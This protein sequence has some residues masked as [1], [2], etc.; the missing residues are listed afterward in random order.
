LSSTKIVII[1][2]VL[3]GLLFVIF[4]VRGGLR[5]DPPPPNNNERKAN[6]AKQQPPGWT[7]KIEGLFSSLKPKRALEKKTYST[8]ATEPISPDQKQAFRTIKFHLLDGLP[9]VHYKNNTPVTGDLHDLEDQDC[10]KLDNPKT[11]DPTHCSI[12]AL[13]DGG[14]ITISCQGTN[15]PCRVEVE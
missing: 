1:V 5:H 9:L 8:N 3:I 15:I 7:K 6:A 10:F 14:T 4:V 12:V 2:L 11:S 13:K